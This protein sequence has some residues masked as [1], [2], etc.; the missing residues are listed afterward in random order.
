LT[1]SSSLSVSLSKV[2]VLLKELSALVDREA[3]GISLGVDSASNLV[4][5][6]EGKLR[7]K[8]KTAEDRQRKIAQLEGDVAELEKRKSQMESTIS[9][10]N[11]TAEQLSSKLEDLR[12]TLTS[13]KNDVTA[14]ANELVELEGSIGEKK[15]Q[16]EKLR[17]DLQA[18]GKK[19]LFEID[20]LRKSHEEATTKSSLMEA[21]HKALR[22]LVREKTIAL[23]E[24]KIIEILESQPSSNIEHLQRMTQSRRDE[25]DTT[26]RS[27]VRRGV[28]SYDSTSGEV[29]VLHPLGI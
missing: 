17:Q 3:S 8:G 7:D 20:S 18:M 6:L 9:E 15:R 26:I 22:L 2:K 16:A 1:E 21:Q 13:K 27:L 10:K 25:I 29:K 14:T 24:L 12:Q 11:S 23:P 19:H 4:K 5:H 28:L